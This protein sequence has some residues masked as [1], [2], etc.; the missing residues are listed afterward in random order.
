MLR[1]YCILLDIWFIEP[2]NTAVF[3]CKYGIPFITVRN[4]ESSRNSSRHWECPEYVFK[5]L[6]YKVFYD[7]ND[8]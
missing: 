6:V 2:Y 7:Y 5:L 8:I 1:K 3:A 4:W